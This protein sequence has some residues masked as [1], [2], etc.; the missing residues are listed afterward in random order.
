[1]V[2]VAAGIPATPAPGH[3]PTATGNPPAPVP[4]EEPATSSADKA[5]R[6]REVAFRGG[7]ATRRFGRHE[8]MAAAARYCEESESSR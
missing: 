8:A 4:R 7:T 5:S 2:A 6:G 3:P 1:M